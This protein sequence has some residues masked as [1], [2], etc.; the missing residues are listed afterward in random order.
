MSNLHHMQTEFL[1]AALDG[2]PTY[3]QLSIVKAHQGRGISLKHFNKFAQHV[4]EALK[5]LS[6]NPQEIEAVIARINLLATEVT[7]NSTSL[8]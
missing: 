1:R 3:T 5:E 6:V 2:P 8:G 4:L 7:G